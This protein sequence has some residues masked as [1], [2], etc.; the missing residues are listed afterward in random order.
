MEENIDDSVK[1]ERYH[2][3]NKLYGP[4]YSKNIRPAPDPHF[5]LDKFYG[6]LTIEEYRAFLE[7]PSIFVNK[8]MT[9]IQGSYEIRKE[10]DDHAL[11]SVYKVKL[12]SEHVGVSKNELLQAAFKKRVPP[13]G[14]GAL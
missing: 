9:L 11:P 7:T 10:T 14:S 8:P 1:F 4:C 13:G 6:D 5:L 12:A 2:L 3:I